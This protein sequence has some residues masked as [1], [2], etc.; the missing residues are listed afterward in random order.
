MKLG[1]LGGGQLAR[2]LAL[3][4]LPLGIRC[5]VLDPSPDAVAGHVAELL[6]GDYDDPRQL[7]EL[8]RGVDAVTFEFENVPAAAIEA[9][10]NQ[11]T[12]VAPNPRALAIAQD[13]IA[14]KTLFAQLGFCV[15]P[16]RAAD[17]AA[18]LAAAITAI[19][20]P[21]LVKTRRLGYDGKGQARV[22]AGTDPNRAAAAVLAELRPDLPADRPADLIVEGF[23]PFDRELSVLA[24]RSRRG[25][26]AIY[27]LVQNVHR[28]GILH[29]STA[30]APAVPAAVRAAAERFVG[31][32]LAHLDYVGVLAVELFL[33]GD[34]LLA[35]EMAPR[36]HNSGH[37]TI[38]GARCSQFENHV[39]AVL[40]LPLGDPASNHPIAMMRN[41]VG[42]MPERAAVLAIPGA[43]WHDYGKA[44]RA[45]RKLGHVT[46]VAPDT[47]TAEAI[48]ARVPEA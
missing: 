2:M 21:C 37:W 15:P 47:S 30:P 31:D 42:S 33:V 14:E 40:D 13:R 46:V 44:P 3:A 12:P 8:A 34:R 39:R 29:L 48:L 32:L 11:L 10:A 16:F 28:R 43:H 41:V 6:V 36:V 38:E 22:A 7:A 5:K 9:L 20:T 27:P 26:I 23:V 17:T 4:A 45:G 24:V 35:N 18:E 25:E 1:I 19:G